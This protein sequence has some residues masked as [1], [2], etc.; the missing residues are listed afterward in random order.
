MGQA[1]GRPE[2]WCL[3]GGCAWAAEGAGGVPEAG[4]WLAAIGLDAGGASTALL[5][6]VSGRA[7]LGVAE[8]LARKARTSSWG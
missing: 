1:G 4:G 2:V 5:G 8:V 7:V 3:Q 6:A